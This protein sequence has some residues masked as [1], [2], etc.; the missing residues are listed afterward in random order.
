MAKIPSSRAPKTS[1]VV[2]DTTKAGLYPARL[3]RFAGLGTQPQPAYDGQA[4]DPAP[5]VAVMFELYDPQT[6]KPLDVIGTNTETNEKV[7]RPSCVFQDYYLFP[8][9]TRGK[10]FELAKALDPSI[11]KVPDNFEWFLDRLSTP[12]QVQVGNYNKKD[13]TIGV[14][15][16]SVTGVSSFVANAMEPARSELVGFD[17]YDD[18]V[19]K[20]GRAY[21]Q[22]FGFQR[23]MLK[24][25]QDAQYIPL[26]GTQPMKIDDNPAN[27]DNSQASASTTTTT[28]SAPDANPD[29]GGGMAADEDDDR[30][31]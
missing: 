7:N 13:G 2:Y 14:K 3:V 11:E 1:K 31:F 9:A 23:D 4:K 25:A 30:P 15:V 12:V 21:A 28:Y 26:A 8:G 19:E 16:A 10:V 18:N 20:F 24:D 17:P 27:T 22:L 29:V 6:A 5:K